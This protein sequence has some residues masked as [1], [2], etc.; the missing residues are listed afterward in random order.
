VGVS[1]LR[2][3]KQHTETRWADAPW[4]GVAVHR[5]MTDAAG[6]AVGN[7]LGVESLRLPVGVS[8]EDK[9]SEVG[10]ERIIVNAKF[11][12]RPPQAVKDALS[13]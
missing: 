2:I 7:V 8:Y 1:Q 12:S 3:G 11:V 4:Q 9:L 13:G 6:C 10:P 5:N